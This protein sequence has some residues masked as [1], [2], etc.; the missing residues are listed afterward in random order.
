M[1]LVT[2]EDSPHNKTRGFKGHSPFYK[3]FD[4]TVRTRVREKHARV[5]VRARAQHT[6]TQVHRRA[7]LL[8]INAQGDTIE[9]KRDFFS[10]NP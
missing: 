6:R 2:E 1:W 7:S 4:S 8:D 10:K 5:R 9:K 3:R